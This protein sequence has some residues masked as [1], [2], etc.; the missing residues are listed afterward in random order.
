MGISAIILIGSL[1][2]LL[3]LGVPIA[4]CMA[5]A[6]IITMLYTGEMGLIVFPQRIFATVDSFP[7]LAIIFFMLAGEL[8]M[9]SGMSKRLVNFVN[10]FM[11]GVRGSLALISLVTC[12]FFGALSG[13]AMATTAAVG[14][15]MYPEMIKDGEYEKSFAAATQAVGGTL[16]TMIPPSITLVVYATLTNTS[17]GT[18]FMAVFVPGVL[19]CIVYCIAGYFLVVRRN[20]AQ[21]KSLPPGVSFFTVFKDAIWALLTPVI[22]LGGIYSGIFTPTESA[23]IACFYALFVGVFVYRELT[24]KIIVNALRRSTIGAAGVL[25][26]CACA[27]LFAWVM[28]VQGIANVIIQFLLGI[29]NNKVQFLIIANITYLI[30]GMFMDTGAIQLLL[31]PLFFLVANALGVDLIHYGVITCIN[32]SVG[33]ITPPFGSCLFVANGIDRSIPIEKIYKQVIPFCI[34]ALVGIGI[35]TAIPILSTWCK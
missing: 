2:L 14:N 30:F 4:V 15:V 18:L 8:M 34:A 24:V 12:A 13:S 25:F 23:A 33:T 20:M 29:I 16:G 22:I 26:L 7:F 19:M 17:V 9:L 31:T 35:I 10:F 3:V 28:Q 27:G 5:G 32:L 11:H 21:S 1:L 6:A